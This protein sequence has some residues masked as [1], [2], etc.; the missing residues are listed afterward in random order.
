MR[1]WEDRS[2]AEVRLCWVL[3][4]NTPLQQLQLQR[5]CVALRVCQLHHV[6]VVLLA[7]NLAHPLHAHTFAKLGAL[8]LFTVSF[9]LW[10]VA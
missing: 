10:K 7:D 8:S 5:L 3:N 6:T 2:V 1:R 4:R 9:T